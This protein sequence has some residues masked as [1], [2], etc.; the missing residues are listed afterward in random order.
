MKGLRL[1]YLYLDGQYLAYI[2]LSVLV[3]GTMIAL[4]TLLLLPWNLKEAK[5]RY[6]LGYQLIRFISGGVLL[7]FGFFLPMDV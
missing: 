2:L 7:A 3:A 6:V 4:G 5:G 1:S